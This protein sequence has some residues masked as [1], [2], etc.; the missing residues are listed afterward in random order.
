MINKYFLE[1]PNILDLSKR[2]KINHLV[3]ASSSSVYGEQKR[4]PFKEYY[5]ITNP[6]QLY[7]ATKVSNEVMAAAY[8]NL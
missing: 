5:N 8:A 1:E 3:F 4:Y 2:F 7:A 6:T